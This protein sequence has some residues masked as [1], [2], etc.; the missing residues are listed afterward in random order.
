LARLIAASALAREESRGVHRRADRPRVDPALDLG[1]T[2]V[3]ADME[4]RIDRWPPV[5]TATPA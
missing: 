5:A 1:H 2:V 4:V 3:G